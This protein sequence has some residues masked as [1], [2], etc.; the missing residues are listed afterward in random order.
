ML[1]TQAL[2]G[3]QGQSGALRR[4]VW[5]LGQPQRQQGTASCQTQSSASGIGSRALPRLWSL[6]WGPSKTLLSTLLLLGNRRAQT[7]RQAPGQLKVGWKTPRQL[8]AG[9]Q[10]PSLTMQQLRTFRQTVT[11]EKRLKVAPGQAVLLATG[12]A[13]CAPLARIRATAC[14]VRC[15]S[16][17]GGPPWTASLAA[18]TAS[19][20][21]PAVMRL[22]VAR[23]S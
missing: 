4:P 3:L 17:C 12:P 21:S 18:Q 20:P 19:R 2:A 1:N 6:Q 11:L 22:G 8:E 5:T 9:V 23:G 16:T 15:A 14:A 13:S 10:V 7:L